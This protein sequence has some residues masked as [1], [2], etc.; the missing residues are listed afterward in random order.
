MG[1]VFGL[2]TAL[3]IIQGHNS[4]I[5]IKSRLNEGTTIQ[6]LFPSIDTR[7]KIRNSSN[8]F[9]GQELGGTILVADD[10]E[11]VLK[12]AS[13]TLKKAGFTVLDASNGGDAVELFKTNHDSIKL[14][15][16][17]MTMPIMNGEQVMRE[18]KHL[19]HDM[20]VVLMSGYSEQ[21][22]STRFSEAGFDGF[23][24]KPFKPRDI[25]ERIQQI[26]IG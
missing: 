20:P 3:G 23:I 15:L 9:L 21:E 22:L 17:D 7:G 13:L 1:R 4:S 19:N 25:I 24:Q 11:S 6:V 14:V 8:D 12:V 5:A 26:L 18:I 16:L 2:S 10:E